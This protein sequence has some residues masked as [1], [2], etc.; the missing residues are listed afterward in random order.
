MHFTI[1]LWSSDKVFAIKFDILL[2]SYY[3]SDTV[4]IQ[5]YQSSIGP[6]INNILISLLFY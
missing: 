1:I 5:K 3:T 6:I 2:Q 4:K